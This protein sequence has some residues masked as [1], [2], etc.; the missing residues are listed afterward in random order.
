MAKKAL[1]GRRSEG[2][3]EGSNRVWINSDHNP[4]AFPWK[5]DKDHH[6]F[7]TKTWELSFYPH[8]TPAGIGAIAILW[9]RYL[10]RLSLVL[11][12]GCPVEGQTWGHLSPW[13]C[14]L[15]RTEQGA[16]C[17]RVL[18]D[19]SGCGWAEHSGGQPPPLLPQGEHLPRR[20]STA[21]RDRKD[22][23]G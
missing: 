22:I 12:S 17:P 16:L 9:M 10:K 23:C 14:C 21:L 3:E 1:W 7:Y 5:R 15:S 8:S 13:W 11:N 4:L 6:W 18:Q 20:E 19:S 2:E